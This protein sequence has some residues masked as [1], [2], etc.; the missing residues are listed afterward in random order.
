MQE[1]RFVSGWTDF[2][3]IILDVK[4]YHFSSNHYFIQITNFKSILK[5]GAM[6][7]DYNSSKLRLDWK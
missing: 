3:A 4:L 5:I 1:D 2:G 6:K 7:D